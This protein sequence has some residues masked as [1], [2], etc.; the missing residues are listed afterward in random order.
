[1]SP[2]WPLEMLNTT[3]FSEKNG[4]TTVTIRLAP[5]NATAA[6]RAA[7]AAGHDSMRG[8]FTGTFDQL[9]EHLSKSKS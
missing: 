1:M 6:E 3:T 9:A 5:H 2:D 4:K 8:G 7:F